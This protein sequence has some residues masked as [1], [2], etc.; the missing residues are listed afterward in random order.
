MQLPSNVRRAILIE[1]MA[2][3]W[4]QIFFL[5]I[6]FSYSL[7]ALAV[8]SKETCQDVRL[9][10]TNGPFTKIPIYNQ[11][12]FDTREDSPSQNFS[13]HDISASGENLCYAVTACQLIDAN[14]FK[15]DKSLNQLCSPVS[16]ALNHKTKFSEL[17]DNLLRGT[18]VY[19]EDEKASVI[20]PG[21]SILAIMANQ[22]QPICDQRW[23]E[24]YASMMA[25]NENT[26]VSNDPNGRSVRSFFTAAFQQIDAAAAVSNSLA[27]KAPTL[28][29][30]FE[31]RSDNSNTQ[32]ILK[33][34]QAAAAASDPIPRAQI[35]LAK[36]CK[37]HSFSAAFP[38]PKNYE[39]I[40]MALDRPLNDLYGSTSDDDGK[41]EILKRIGKNRAQRRVEKISSLLSGPNPKPVGIGY[42]HSML[43][44]K[45]AGGGWADHTSIIIGQRW[46]GQSCEFL[47]RD[48]YGAKNC[49][50]ALYPCDNGSFWIPQEALSQSTSSVYWIP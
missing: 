23:F 9:D 4:A 39:G 44:D 22:G 34:A 35:F 8:I 37:D 45:N 28:N 1:V 13:Q 31:C 16:L 41:R 18:E 24:K 40:E 12:K 15:K 33:I 27:S 50:G 48:S 5:L 26:E 19:K 11:T 10:K 32:D 42:V 2:N 47:L 29:K 30:Y 6:S 49:A 17:P 7:N 14:R 25:G 3:F 20:G 36:L 21:N 43:T 38:Q 46:N